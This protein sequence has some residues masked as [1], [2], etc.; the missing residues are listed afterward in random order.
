MLCNRFALLMCYR[1]IFTI[2]LA[3]AIAGC[4]SDKCGSVNCLNEG[5]CVRGE[6]TCPFA[7]EGE[8]CQ[9]KWNDKFNGQWVSLETAG[10][11][12]LRNYPL[13]VVAGSSPDSFY[14]LHLAESVDTVFCT[15]K[16]YKTFTMHERILPDSSKIQGGEGVYNELNGKVTGVYS[17]HKQDVVTTISFTWS[18]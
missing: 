5:V 12:T 13:N 17:F 14:I 2:L 8:F 10:A 9:S 7:W 18:K 15:R 16:A 6:C 3:L 1:F 4:I 11:D